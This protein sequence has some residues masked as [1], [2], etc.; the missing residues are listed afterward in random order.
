MELRAEFFRKT[1]LQCG[2]IDCNQSLDGVA[3]DGLVGPARFQDVSPGLPRPM[4][5]R[6]AER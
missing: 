3:A 2:E 4:G 5:F 1:R 6:G